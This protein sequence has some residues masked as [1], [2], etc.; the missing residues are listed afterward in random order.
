MRQSVSGTGVASG[1]H[2]LER[3]RQCKVIVGAVIIALGAM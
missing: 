1:R 2:V 3:R